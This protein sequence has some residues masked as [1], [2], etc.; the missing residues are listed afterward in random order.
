MGNPGDPPDRSKTTRK[1]MRRPFLSDPA[2]LPSDS[3]TIPLTD[4]STRAR[5]IGSAARSWALRTGAMF[6]GG[7]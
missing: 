5:S 4:G 3:R 7:N 6:G 2:T 1:L